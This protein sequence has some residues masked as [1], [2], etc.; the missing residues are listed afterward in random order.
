MVMVNLFQSGGINAY[1]H[2]PECWQE[3]QPAEI[4]EFARLQLQ[5][6][7]DQNA[8][9][10]ALLLFLIK[11]RAKQQNVHLPKLWQL[12]INR[13]DFTINGIPLLNFLYNEIEMP[14]NPLP[15]ITVGSIFKTKLYGPEA[16]FTNITCG[17]FE[18]AEQ[19]YFQFVQEP[20]P[21]ALAQLMAILWRPKNTP[22]HSYNKN[23][24]LKAIQRLKPEIL[25]TVYLF[26]TASRNCLPALFPTIYEGD[27]SKADAPDNMAFTKCIHAAAGPKNGTREQIR[28]M[29]LLELMYDMELEA[30][31]AKKLQQEYE[32]HQRSIIH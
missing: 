15:V 17:E 30:I 4:I 28:K 3:L 6:A 8:A 14:T 11:Y 2:L 24:Y 7:N 29:L 20:N 10:A 1:V 31:N 16:N 22:Y 27:G 21:T 13:Q 12:G 26:Y 32:Q 19:Q 18:D 5:Y 9:K 23:T 25:F